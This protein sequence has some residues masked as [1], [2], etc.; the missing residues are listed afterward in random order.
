MHFV[1]VVGF[2]AL[3]GAGAGWSV[4]A[5]TRSV[6]NP[7]DFHSENASPQ[8]FATPP[9][10]VDSEAL[11]ET[12]GGRYALSLVQGDYEAVVD[13]V[14]WM[15]ERLNRIRLQTGDEEAVFAA[16]ADLLEGLGR[17]TVAENQLTPEGV[18]DKYVFAP[19]AMLEWLAQEDG[20][21]D[22]EAPAARSDWIAV[23]YPSRAR[24]LRDE[25]NIPIHRIV[26]GVH[27]D[28]GGQVLKAGVEGNLDILRDSIGYD[29]PDEE[30]E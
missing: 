24:A 30:G 22:L 17:R 5:L 9:V 27:T 21:D 2:C 4:L 18:E 11:S 3:M 14:L 23:R 25:E 8:R 1:V 12:P 20:R 15:N 6:S 16:R 29:W 10:A 13:Q 28:R 19:G 7:P 26:V